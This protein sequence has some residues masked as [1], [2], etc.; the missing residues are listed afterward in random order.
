MLSVRRWM[1]LLFA[2]LVLAS[3]GCNS[4]GNVAGKVTYKK[5]PMPGGSVLFVAVNGGSSVSA[6]INPV[7]GTYSVDNMRGGEMKVYVQPYGQPGGLIP[8][9]GNTGPKS[10]GPPKDIKFPEGMDAKRYEQK[11]SGAR[12]VYV[13]DQFA[14]S[15]TTTLRVTIK[16]GTTPF[17]IDIP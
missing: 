16:A 7:D 6:T 4:R 9:G 3:A 11:E 2:A 14:N 13:P 12:Y 1:P 5:A 8:M 10:Y 17:D 15:E